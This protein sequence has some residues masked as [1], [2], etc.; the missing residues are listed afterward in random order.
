LLPATGAIRSVATAARCGN[1]ALLIDEIH[2]RR[3]RDCAFPRIR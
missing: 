1:A 3:R 2:H